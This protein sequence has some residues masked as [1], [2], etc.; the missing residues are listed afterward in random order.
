VPQARECWQK[1]KFFSEKSEDWYKTFVKMIKILGERKYE[2]DPTRIES[3][4]RELK[5]RAAGN[6]TTEPEASSRLYTRVNR[7]AG[8]ELAA[9][10]AG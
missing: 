7:G 5:T 10:H 9:L 1:S 2:R 3:C 6:M 4:R 8:G